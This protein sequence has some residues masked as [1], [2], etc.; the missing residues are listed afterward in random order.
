MRLS[1]KQ[2]D[3]FVNAITPFVL[4]NEKIELR[5][6]GSRLD[7][8]LH[9]GDIDLLIVCDSEIIRNHIAAHKAEILAKIYIA[10]DEENIDILIVDIN[11]LNDGAFVKS[12]FEASQVIHTWPE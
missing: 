2:V 7:D 1:D 10:L 9:G 8:E 6:Y 3:S 5:L 11:K 4:S 12:A